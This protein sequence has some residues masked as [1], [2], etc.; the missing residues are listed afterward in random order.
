M[1]LLCGQSYRLLP[2]FTGVLK[3]LFNMSWQEIIIIIIAL[4]AVLYLIRFFRRQV[5]SHD[6]NDCALM[7]MKKESDKE[8]SSKQV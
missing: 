1:G 3:H 8:L 7:D 2:N 6:C 4:G 5:K